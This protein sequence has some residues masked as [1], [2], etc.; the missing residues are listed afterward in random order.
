MKTTLIL[1]F[2]C[3]F[4]LNSNAQLTPKQRLNYEQK[5]RRYEDMHEYGPI[6]VVFGPLAAGFG[7]YLISEVSSNTLHEFVGDV[8]VAGL[9]TGVGLV[10]TAGGIVYTFTGKRKADEYKRKLKLG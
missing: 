7:I 10:V 1:L 2:V 3:L 6:L 5:V 8:V 9:V 4:A